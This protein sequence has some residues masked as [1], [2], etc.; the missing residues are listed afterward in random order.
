MTVTALVTLDDV[1]AHL[2]VP[3]EDDSHDVELQGFIDA[4]TAQVQ[5]WTGPV[6]PTTF[7]DEVHDGGYPTVAL[8]NP[9][10]LTVASV[11]EYIGTVAYQLTA[12]PPGSTVDNYGY[13]LDDP[14]AGI[15]VRRDGAGC[16]TRFMGG[17]RSVVVSY[18]AGLA[19]VPGDIRLATLEDIRGLYQQTQQGGRPSFGGGGGGPDDI[20]SSDPIRAFPRLAALLD[21]PGRTPSIA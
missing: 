5:Y 14:L 18:T 16:P 10:I 13:S 7:T 6:I 20:W 1:R 15:L 17:P 2:N 21:G 19:A 4:A 3:D 8:F 12:Q 11:T 9:P